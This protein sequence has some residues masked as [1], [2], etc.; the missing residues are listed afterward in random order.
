[1]SINATVQLNGF[2]AK[3]PIFKEDTNGKEYAIVNISTTDSYRDSDG[4]WQN[5][6]TVFHNGVFAFNSKVVDALKAM[7]QKDRIKAGG[8][9]IG[10]AGTGKTTALAVVV[11]HYKQM[12][13]KVSGVAL[14]GIAAKNL[15][16]STGI[17]T[18][19]IA[20]F[21]S[22]MEQGYLD[23]L[24]GGVVIV[25][26]AGMVD[27]RTMVKLL[28]LANKHNIKL[29]LAG[30]DKQLPA[31]QAGAA[32][33]GIVEQTDAAIM[34]KVWRQQEHWQ[35]EASVAFSKG[36]AAKALQAYIEHGC[37]DWSDD[38]QQAREHIARDYV[39]YISKHPDKTCLI[40]AHSNQDV[41]RLN[42]TIREQLKAEGKVK[43]GKDFITQGGIKEFGTGDRILF[44]END[45]QQMDVRN[46]MTGRVERVWGSALHV[47]LDDGRKIAVNSSRY[48]AFTHGYAA[49]LHKAQGS[50]VDCSFIYATPTLTQELAYVGLSR[51][52]E[53]ATLYADHTSLKDENALIASVERSQAKTL[54]NDY[55][56]YMQPIDPVEE[57][58][59]LTKEQENCQKTIDAYESE[60]LKLSLIMED[61]AQAEQDMATYTDSISEK[62]EQ[63]SELVTTTF[64]NGKKLAKQLAAIPDEQLHSTVKSWLRDQKP[65]GTILSGHKQAEYSS[66]QLLELARTIAT[67]DKKRHDLQRSTA[68]E[69]PSHTK[70]SSKTTQHSYTQAKHHQKTLE[71]TI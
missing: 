4:S 27:T 23:E 67:L 14:A 53:S 30:D 38:K 31:I 35:Q 60:Q 62:R 49:T 12:G 54:F 50:T 48:K 2:L 68:A 7:K 13:L 24:K 40:E 8:K 39:A 43:D 36:N 11:E 59:R 33:R 34:E 52:R 18:S 21:L 20:R 32:F 57:I 1:M 37:I 15:S 16:E 71:K 64:K 9:L 61:R 55:D 10:R 45:Y 19:T 44:L 42:L 70:N 22:S 25:D 58:L 65:A 41:D 46:G 56:H 28:T 26:E 3:D 69:H 47:K 29:V 17:K 5:N 63:V 6:Q 66:L 51:H